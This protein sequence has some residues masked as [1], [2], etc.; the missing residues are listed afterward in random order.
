MS[1]SAA[2]FSFEW[3]E[4][5]SRVDELADFFAAQV[6]AD[7]V[8]HSELQSGRACEPGRW[9]DDLA[10][11]LCGEL[12]GMLAAG[13]EGGRLV[14]VAR[15]AGRLAAL[16]LVSVRR[17]GEGPAAFATLEDLIVGDAYRGSGLGRSMLSWLETE[18]TA[19]GIRRLFLESGRKNLAAHRFFER[20]GFIPV[21]V[22]MMKDLC[23]G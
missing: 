9:N 6:S 16:G 13:T 20:N 7:Y 14:A 18:L 1:R 2:V 10:G 17:D 23:G 5:P 3:C 8:S 22:V 4:D 21:S 11:V 19:R 12:T 15:Q